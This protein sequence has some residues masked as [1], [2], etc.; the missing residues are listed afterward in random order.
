MQRAALI[1]G[2]RDLASVAEIA[3]ESIMRGIVFAP[4][5]YFE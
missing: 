2:N 3:L 5:L 4:S 1:I